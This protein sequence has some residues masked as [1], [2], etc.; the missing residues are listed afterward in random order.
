VSKGAQARMI[1][2]RGGAKI[3]AIRD[4]AHAL[5]EAFLGR[6][7]DLKLTVKTVS[8]ADMQE[9]QWIREEEA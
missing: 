6:H 9:A 8:P 1:V 7:V 2:G 3:Q 4:S 5:C